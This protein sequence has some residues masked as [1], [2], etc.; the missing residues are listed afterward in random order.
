[1]T[2]IISAVLAVILIL[3]GLNSMFVVSEGQNALSPRKRK[4]STSTFT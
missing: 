1:M 2:R 4:A 3:L